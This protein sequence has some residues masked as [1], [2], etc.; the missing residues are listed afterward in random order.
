MLLMKPKLGPILIVVSLAVAASVP[1]DDARKPNVLFISVDDLND[2]IGCL[3]GHPQAKTP[4][5]D[6]LAASG[7]LFTNAYC[8]AASCN[9]S[10]SALMSGIP[11]HQSGLYN[12]MQKMRKVMPDA[13]LIPKYW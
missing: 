5:L 2:W 3:G 4:N 13:E 6:R 8:P 10:R 1:A 9:P 7:V 12:N 11:P